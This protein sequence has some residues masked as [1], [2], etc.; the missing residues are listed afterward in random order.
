ME[1]KE[2]EKLKEQLLKQESSLEQELKEIANQNPDSSEDWGSKFP[3]FEQ[4][5]FDIEEAADEVEEYVNRLPVEHALELKLKATKE[6]LEKMKENKY[7]ICEN[8]GNS[9]PK[10]RLEVI[11]EARICMTCKEKE[12]N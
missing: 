10:E 4:E 9:I 5:D 11:P 3:N 6:A 12:D 1:K 8:C 7:G 2:L